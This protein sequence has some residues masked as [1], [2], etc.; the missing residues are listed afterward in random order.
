MEKRNNK[1]KYSGAFIPINL[2]WSIMNTR[3]RLYKEESG[4]LSRDWDKVIVLVIPGL[5]L[6]KW[7]LE[8]QK[9]AKTLPYSP[10]G[11]L[12]SSKDTFEPSTAYIHL[13]PQAL[14]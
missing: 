7:A 9:I 12:S 11:I 1:R 10:K 2:V 6:P 4:C 14:P 3:A 13:S 5:K 8:T